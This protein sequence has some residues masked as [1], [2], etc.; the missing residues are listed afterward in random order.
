MFVDEFCKFQHGALMRRLFF[1]YTEGWPGI[2]LLLM[3][4][5]A[6]AALFAGQGGSVIWHGISVILGILLMVGLWTPIAGNTYC[7]HSSVDYLR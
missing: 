4:L 6:G 5:A 3:R 1:T 7:H 2:A